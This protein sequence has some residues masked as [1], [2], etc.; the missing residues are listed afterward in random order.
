MK[1]SRLIAMERNIESVGMA[2][3]RLVQE[4]TFLKDLAVGNMELMKQFDGYESAVEKLKES[5]NKDKE[6]LDL[7]EGQGDT[8]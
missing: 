8:E 2:V 6:E 5:L 7:G 3:Q 4:L 1:E